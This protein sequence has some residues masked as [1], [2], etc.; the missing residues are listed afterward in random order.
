M[1]IAIKNC[2]MTSGGVRIIPIMNDPIIIYDRF[3]L[4]FCGVVTPK[5]IKRIVTTGTSKA[6]PKANDTFSI[7]SK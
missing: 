1:G 5:M 3:F 6:T 7:K 4:S 2:D